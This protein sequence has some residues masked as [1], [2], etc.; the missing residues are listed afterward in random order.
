MT[1]Y[2][3]YGFEREEFKLSADEIKTIRERRWEKDVPKREAEKLEY[4]RKSLVYK[5]MINEL[6]ETVEPKRFYY[7]LYVKKWAE[8]ILTLDEAIEYIIDEK[9]YEEFVTNVSE[10]SLSYARAYIW[11]RLQEERK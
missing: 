8:S 6:Y 10:G 1:D 11:K 5:M 9:R 3:N 4:M 7:L 2:E